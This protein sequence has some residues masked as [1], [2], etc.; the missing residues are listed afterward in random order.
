MTETDNITVRPAAI[1]DAGTVSV[2]EKENLDSAWSEK[3][4]SDSIASGN[5]KYFIAFD[6]GNPV[7]SGGIMM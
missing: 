7:G 1:E 6:K 2:I 3:S 5:Y 4:V